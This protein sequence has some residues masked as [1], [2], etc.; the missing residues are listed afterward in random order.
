MHEHAGGSGGYDPGP[1]A[2]AATGPAARAHAGAP[3]AGAPYACIGARSGD[4]A[5]SAA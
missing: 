2:L 5:S 1:V 4:A 3:Y